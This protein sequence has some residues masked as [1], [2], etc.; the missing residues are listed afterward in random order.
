MAGYFPDWLEDTLGRGVQEWLDLEAGPPKPKA[1]QQKQDSSRGL[2]LPGYNYLGPFNG[3]D[4]G[5][6]V[7][8]ADSAAQKHDQAYQEQ[9]DQGDN[10]YLKYNHADREFQEE[11]SEDTSLGGNLG[12]AVFQAKKRVLEPFGLV[13]DEKTAPIGKKRPRPIEPP[14]SAEHSDDE[15]AVQRRP[16]QPGQSSG[17]SS[18]AASAAGA[19]AAAPASNL[20]SNTMASGGGSPMADDNQGADGVGNASGNWHCDTTWLGD[21]V[22]TRT[23][24][25]W[26]LPTYN[27]HLYNRLNNGTGDNS[28]FGFSTPWGYF[29]FNRFHCHFSP[30]DWQRLIN[31]NWG[32][33]PKS[34]HFKLFNIQVKEVT[35][36]DSTTTIAN[37][38]TSTVQVFA[39]TEYQLPYVIGNAHEGCLP[40]FPA[41]VFMLPQYG[42]CTRQNGATVN[43]TPQSA[44]YCLE[45][46]PSQMLR[47]GNNFSFSYKF[48]KVPFHSMWAHNQTLDRIMNPLIDQYLWFL[49]STS[50]GGNRVL[51]FSKATATNM[52]E[53]G[54]NWL[55]GPGYKTQAWSE[56]AANN[57]GAPQLW[58]YT[59]R[60]TLEG[61]Q[62][63]IAP[64]P[65]LGEKEGTF[66]SG[67]LIFA[68][69]PSTVNNNAPIGD[70]II[71][72]ESEVQTTNFR[73]GEFP[74]LISSNNQTTTTVPSVNNEMV[75]PVMPGQVWMDR[76]IYLQGPIWAKIP[77]TDGHFHPSPLMGGFGLK[78]PP[79]QILIKNTP[80]PGNPPTT[81]TPGKIS[82]FIT[83]YS[84][85]QVT[86]EMEWELEREN[87]KRWNPEIQYS[88]N[89]SATDNSVLH[90]APGTDGLYTEFRTIGSR[91]LTRPI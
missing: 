78:H 16:I 86:V 87:S 72:K 22:I 13:E 12:R 23:T 28:F 50:A 24:R 26:S 56:T 53:Q 83:Q 76:D 57:Y 62:S 66:Q 73:N 74:L 44:F 88:D 36:Q 79:P 71:T 19:G 43:P 9:L 41:D 77:N 60:N 15:E 6:P 17:E 81:F 59:N 11:L 64:G 91:Y 45:Y 80:V 25:T 18:S 65:V 40:P 14:P 89:A 4:R 69:T 20:A 31:N 54:R 85:G 52:A 7:N 3:P 32:I 70:V 33:R 21:R 49:N 82:S 1:N 2:V 68:K 67:T 38:L 29:D 30:R 5:E 8:A 90:F 46:F 48:E 42:Y 10:P 61:R 39:D 34:M 37:N 84:T 35:T 58:Q 47:T 75:A 55:P 63:K 51:G 27:N